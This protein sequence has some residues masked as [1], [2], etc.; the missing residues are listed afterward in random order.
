MFLPGASYFL[1]ITCKLVLIEIAGIDIFINGLNYLSSFFCSENFCSSKEYLVNVFET[2]A[3]VMASLIA[4]VFSISLVMI[5]IGSDKYS[6]KILDFF[7][8]EKRTMALFGISMFTI[9]LTLILMWL[10]LVTML[11]FS[12]IFSMFIIWTI[13]F[14]YY[15]VNIVRITNPEQIAEITVNKCK[16]QIEQ[17]NIRSINSIVVAI[18]DSTISA[19]YRKETNLAMKFINS[20]F[21]LHY[22]ALKNNFTKAKKEIFN[23]FLR[24]IEVLIDTRNAIRNYLWGNIFYV[25]IHEVN[26]Q[27]ELDSNF[28][29]YYTLN[30]LI[31]INKKIIDSDDYNGFKNEIREYSLVLVQDNP[32]M[33]QNDLL[34][35]LI[36]KETLVSLNIINDTDTIN[37]SLD[38]YNEIFFLIFHKSMKNFNDTLELKMYF[39]RY[40]QFIESTLKQNFPNE[41]NFNDK[42]NQIHTNVR[43]L[44][45][46]ICSLYLAYKIHFLY[47]IVGSY[48]VFKK[49]ENKFES[50]VYIKAMWEITDSKNPMVINSNNPPALFNPYWLTLLRL[51]GGTN[52]ENFTFNTS[53]RFQFDTFIDPEK[54]LTNYYIICL[55]KAL[56][57]NQNSP[58]FPNYDIKTE[59]YLKFN[60]QLASAFIVDS[61]KYLECCDDLINTSNEWDILFDNRS[62]QLFLKTRQW[63]IEKIDYCKLFIDNFVKDVEVDATKMQDIT[64]L[65]STAYI[66][67]CSIKNLINI[68]TIKH[69]QPQI[70]EFSPHKLV[71]TNYPKQNLVDDN[72]INYPV[73]LSAHVYQ[74]SGKNFAMR[75]RDYII[76]SLCN[77]PDIPKIYLNSLDL[78]ELNKLINK[79]YHEL[80]E[81]NFKPTCIIMPMKLFRDFFNIHVIDMASSNYVM[82]TGEV[83]KTIFLPCLTFEAVIIINSNIGLWTYKLQENRLTPLKI[84]FD[85]CADKLHVNITVRTDVHLDI[86]NP[87]SAVI[88]YLPDKSQNESRWT[89]KMFKMTNRYL[90][91]LTSKQ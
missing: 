66:E 46:K 82:D 69:P 12:I 86:K 28:I 81:K 5:Q 64:N 67:S 85:Q 50:Q 47:F 68:Q 44:N 31:N 2:A 1:S 42:I 29:D 54:S 49:I 52:N 22:I 34:T 65:I 45:H 51:Y 77:N 91:Y 33:L 43:F 17:R 61:K 89:E 13:I 4:I 56:S 14:W 70:G 25:L 9:L 15:F 71:I 24:I 3:T 21:E 16:L 60:L 7:V 10:N 84:T 19:L 27:N 83:I 90:D 37:Q 76:M 58:Q 62:S 35:D 30:F 38:Q 57:L 75:D 36:H 87:E 88:V 72:L 23:Q 39:E 74:T 8:H 73:T 18:T 6:F 63:I 78:V 79:L 59:D 26:T 20:F 48:I 40:S 55:T 32:L 41:P 80:T 53:L 11:S